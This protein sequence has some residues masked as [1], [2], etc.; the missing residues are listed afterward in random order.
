MSA[1]K[2]TKAVKESV[3][4]NAARDLFL[5]SLLERWRKV[6][7]QF[8]GLVKETFKDFDWEHVEPYRKYMHWHSAICLYNLPAEWQ[9]HWDR[10]RGNLGLPD[11]AAIDIDFE[12]ASRNSGYADCLDSAYKKQA[13]DIL[14]PYMAEYFLA[15]KYYDD[16][17]QILLGIGTSKQLEDVVPEL[18]KY[19]PATASGAATALAPIE[20]INRVRAM[21]Q[22]GEA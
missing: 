5:P 14:R 6:Q 20:Q 15:R 4:I 17:G 22:K 13:E 7:E 18:V 21:T 12:Y 3:A 9:I 1:V 2:M 11:V 8:T 19:L 10:F 16:V